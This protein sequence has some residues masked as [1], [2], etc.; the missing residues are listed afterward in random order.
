MS[1]PA[2]HP[3][4]KRAFGLGWRALVPSWCGWPVFAE[5]DQAIH[6]QSLWV[7]ARG[8]PFH[9]ISSNCF[10]LLLTMARDGVERQARVWLSLESKVTSGEM[11]GGFP[12]SWQPSVYFW[13]PGECLGQFHWAGA[14]CGPCWVCI[15]SRGECSEVK[16]Q[17]P[18]H[19]TYLISDV[20]YTHGVSLRILPWL[21]WDQH[22]FCWINAN[23]ELRETQKVTVISLTI[24]AC[25][26]EA[27]WTCMYWYH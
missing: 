20:Y 10:G 18:F 8:D 6:S 15:T 23:L 12:G 1:I 27:L 17:H 7:D 11:E 19:Y 21:K 13:L 22:R 3:V 9:W 5:I 14:L 2:W 24:Q 25:F 26:M 16:K 4:E